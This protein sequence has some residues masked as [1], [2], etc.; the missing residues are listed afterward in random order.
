MKHKRSAFTLIEI[1]IVVAI[2]A[3]LSGV[4]FSYYTDSLQESREAVVRHN[5][6]TVREA[7]SMYFKDHM[8]YP[9]QL[10]SLTGPYLKESVQQLL[11]HPIGGDATVHVVVPD[12]DNDAA[13]EA[14]MATL[15][16][17]IPYN[18]DIVNV[19]EIKNVKIKYQNNLMT[20]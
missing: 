12:T 14:F 13:P 4:G 3:V 5:L 1:L 17:E 16:I 9:T 18:F 15:T 20:W 10:Q 8:A 7:I 19:K 11:I 2:I 6:K